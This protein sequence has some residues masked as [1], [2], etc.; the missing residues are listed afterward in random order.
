M[1][2]SIL[3]NKATQRAYPTRVLILR[4]DLR[5]YVRAVY[6]T[7]YQEMQRTRVR[8]TVAHIAL[9]EQASLLCRLVNT[10]LSDIQ[11]ESRHC[12]VQTL[13]SV[14]Q[15]FCLG[16]GLQQQLSLS[17]SSGAYQ[18]VRHGAIACKTRSTYSSSL[19]GI[20]AFV[21]TRTCRTGQ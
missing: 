11:L 1:T 16:G 13:P 20:T 10:L 17:R 9:A 21:Q 15:A 14:W 7:S 8:T 2:V 18:Q 4:R 3:R 19:L 6:C 12:R 5:Q